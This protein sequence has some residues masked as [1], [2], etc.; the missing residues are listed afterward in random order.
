MSQHRELTDETY[1][2]VF[3]LVMIRIRAV[4]AFVSRKHGALGSK[5]ADCEVMRQEADIGE[6]SVYAALTRNDGYRELVQEYWRTIGHCD[7][8]IPKLRKLTNDINKGGVIID[9]AKV[10][11][12]SSAVSLLGQELP[13]ATNSA[14]RFRSDWSCSLSSSRQMVL[15]MTG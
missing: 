9:A 11:V 8:A 6:S 13:K 4:A 15:H 1:D 12:W 14:L 2:A 7:K 3:E 5:V 10:D